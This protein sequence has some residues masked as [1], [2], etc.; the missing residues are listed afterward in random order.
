MG[1]I[2]WNG[3]KRTGHRKSQIVRWA[4]FCHYQLHHFL[5]Y[6]SPYD[7]GPILAY[8]PPPGGVTVLYTNGKPDACPSHSIGPIYSPSRYQ[9]F[10]CHKDY[11]LEVQNTQKGFIPSFLTLFA[12]QTNT[13]TWTNDPQFCDRSLANSN[14]PVLNEPLSI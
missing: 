11:K 2:T 5:H 10:I 9:K 7:K 6:N 12:P 3:F 8:C 13:K 4:I 14:L 1:G